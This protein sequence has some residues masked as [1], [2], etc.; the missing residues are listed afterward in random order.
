[1]FFYFCDVS[2]TYHCVEVKYCPR[3]YIMES[4]HVFIVAL[5]LSLLYQSQIGIHFTNGVG[6][7]LK[8][9][10]T[11]DGAMTSNIQDTETISGTK[12]WILN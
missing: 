10:F 3:E 12:C 9:M 2:I 7:A 4:L 6:Y 8:S 11:V 1:M 5:C